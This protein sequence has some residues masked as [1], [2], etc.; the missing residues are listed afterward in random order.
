M[1]FLVIAHHAHYDYAERILVQTYPTLRAIDDQSCVRYL[2]NFAE[3]SKNPRSYKWCGSVS[4]RTRERRCHE[5]HRCSARLNSTGGKMQKA[6]LTGS[7]TFR[8]PLLIVCMPQ[9]SLTWRT[10]GSEAVEM[11]MKLA[12]QY[13]FGVVTSTTWPTQL[14]HKDRVL[15][16]LHYRCIGD[17]R[18]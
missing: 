4:H 13:F 15:A 6:L 5:S 3:R 16:W 17:G 1:V 12:R 7:G 9:L 8:S 2:A 18:L 10:L 11:A 14:H